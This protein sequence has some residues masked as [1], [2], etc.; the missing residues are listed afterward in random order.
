MHLL[1]LAIL[2]F[3]SLENIAYIIFCA[4]IASFLQYFNNISDRFRNVLAILQYFQGIFQQFCINISVLC[5][6]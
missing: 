4:D 1:I 5:G 2:Q 3:G 6:T